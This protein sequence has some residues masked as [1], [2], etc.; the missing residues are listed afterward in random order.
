MTVLLSSEEKQMTAHNWHNVP[1]IK[2][3]FKVNKGLI[4]GVRLIQVSV[5]FHCILSLWM[6]SGNWRKCAHSNE[7]Y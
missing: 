3:S 2:V 7:S 5:R 6:K 4:E 1:L